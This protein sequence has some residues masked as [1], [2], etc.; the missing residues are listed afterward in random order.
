MLHHIRVCPGLGGL[1]LIVGRLE[2][3]PETGHGGFQVSLTVGDVVAVLVLGFGSGAQLGTVLLVASGGG[4]TFVL[5]LVPVLGH[6]GAE[7]GASCM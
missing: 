1:G 2:P 5:H 3:R 4:L 7:L 6:F